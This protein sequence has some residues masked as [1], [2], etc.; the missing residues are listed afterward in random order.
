MN[1]LP[2]NKQ[3]TPINVYISQPMGGHTLEEILEVRNNVI[4]FIKKLMPNTELIFIDNV[5]INKDYIGNSMSHPGLWYFA[6]SIKLMSEADIIIFAN[7]WENSVGCRLE[8]DIANEF[9]I[10]ML[11]IILSE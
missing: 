10:K 7:D 6:E 1:E 5:T 2:M 8:R 9:N 4:D 3:T 11:D